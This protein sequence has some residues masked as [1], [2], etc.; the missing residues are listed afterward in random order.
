MLDQQLKPF[1]E[2]NSSIYKMF[3]FL[4]FNYFILFDLLMT[5][6]FAFKQLTLLLKLVESQS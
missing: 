1:S 5:E 2:I 3:S 4:F 6:L